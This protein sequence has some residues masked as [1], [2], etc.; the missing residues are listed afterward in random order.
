LP[1]RVEVWAAR[2][3]GREQRLAE[4]PLR[5]VDVLADR[6]VEAAGQALNTPYV[7]FGH[8][9]GASV[10]F[11]V[12]R[13]AKQNFGLEPRHLFVSSRR[14]PHFP[15]TDDRPPAHTLTDEEF[16]DRLRELGG[17]P[18]EI[19]NDKEMLTL[20][21]PALRADFEAAETYEISLPDAPELSCPVT[22]IGGTDDDYVVRDHL[23]EWGEVTSGPFAVE[24]VSGDHFFIDRHPNQLLDI[25]TRK[26]S[27]VI[28]AL[29]Y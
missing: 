27:P 6:A 22:A 5:S 9:L 17:I 12:A 19:L 15:R 4:S 18:P 10:A 13:R 29:S 7:L 2:P 8:S 26:L 14:A 21:L 16:V 23:E 11:E 3:P 1:S 28:E 25:V 24:F 20:V